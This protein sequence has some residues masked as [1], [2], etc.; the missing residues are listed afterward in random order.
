[1]SGSVEIRAIEEET[2]MDLSFTAVIVHRL[3]AIVEEQPHVQRYHLGGDGS[4]SSKTWM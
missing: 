2:G 3:A 4:T 1:M